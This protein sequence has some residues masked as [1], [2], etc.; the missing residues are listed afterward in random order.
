MSRQVELIA[1]IKLY[2]KVAL[3]VNIS[4]LQYWSNI[5]VNF[6]YFMLDKML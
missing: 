1:R 5:K 6:Q 4:G 3:T 2:C